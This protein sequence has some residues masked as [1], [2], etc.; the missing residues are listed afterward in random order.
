MPTREL[1]RVKEEKAA[2]KRYGSQLVTTGQLG[3][4]PRRNSTHALEFLHLRDTRAGDPS[5]TQFWVEDHHGG[6]GKIFI[7]K[8]LSL[9]QGYV[10]RTPSGRGMQCGIAGI[11]K[12][13][14]GAL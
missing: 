9:S 2:K 6:G 14:L 11:G 10:Q 7:L 8:Y 1:E 12:A 5:S 13:G 4:N 3:W